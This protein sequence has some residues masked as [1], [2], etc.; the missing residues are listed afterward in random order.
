MLTRAAQKK[1]VVQAC[2]SNLA[3]PLMK[4]GFEHYIASNHT[5]EKGEGSFP[6]RKDLKPGLEKSVNVVK[7]D[8]EGRY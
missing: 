1:D 4:K 3:Q 8:A 6:M 5:Q 7:S 2:V